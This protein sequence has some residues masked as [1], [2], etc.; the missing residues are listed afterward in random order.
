MDEIK[1]WKVSIHIIKGNDGKQGERGERGLPGA[2]GKDGEPGYTP[3]RGNDYWT[4]SDKTE[5]ITETTAKTK[6]AIQPDLDKISEQ[7]GDIE[8]VLDLINGE[9]V[10]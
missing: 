5:I 8:Q 10:V 6:E 2:T 9:S 3:I 4:E 7:L 1:L